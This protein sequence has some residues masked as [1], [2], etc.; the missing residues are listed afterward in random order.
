MY[1]LKK[2]KRFNYYEYYYKKAKV[3]IKN[4]KKKDNGF[5]NSINDVMNGAPESAILKSEKE[6]EII[7]NQQVEI[8]KDLKIPESLLR[9]YKAR[10]VATSID[11]HS[12]PKQKDLIIELKNDEGDVI[13]SSEYTYKLKSVS[14]QAAGTGL[15]L[16]LDMEITLANGQKFKTDAYMSQNFCD[17]KDS[18]VKINNTN[19]VSISRYNNNTIEGIERFALSGVRK[20]IFNNHKGVLTLN[21]LDDINKY[22]FHCNAT[23]NV[24]GK[25]YTKDNI[26]IS[27]TIIPSTCSVGN[28][29][30]RSVP[31]SHYTPEQLKEMEKRFEQEV[32]EAK[33]EREYKE[34][35]AK[36]KKE[37][38]EKL[39]KESK[40]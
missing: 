31:A 10:V 18:P 12:K 23:L 25:T 3:V 34:K 4:D 14:H 32:K 1:F 27:V 9:Q 5:I 40:H 26:E 19:K 29:S 13:K 37:K 22:V 33:E 39:E 36:L 7:K 30:A 24:N 8:E 11:N 20:Q 17:K 16:M 38:E 35:V 6:K 28:I 15:P 21:V 2:D